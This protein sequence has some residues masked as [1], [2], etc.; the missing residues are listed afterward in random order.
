MGFFIS[1]EN[2]DLEA[3]HSLSPTIIENLM[4]HV[5][6]GMV[7]KFTSRYEA[8]KEREKAKGFQDRAISTQESVRKIFLIFVT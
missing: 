3:F 1:E 6:K 5:P 7:A 8:W 2:I 4:T